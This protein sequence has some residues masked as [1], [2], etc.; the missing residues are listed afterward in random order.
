MFLGGILSAFRFLNIP[1][2]FSLLD[3]YLNNRTQIQ[4]LIEQ[5]SAKAKTE[6]ECLD[7]KTAEYNNTIEDLKAVLY[8]SGLNFE[9][10]SFPR[11]QESEKKPAKLKPDQ[12]ISN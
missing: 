9:S 7:K 8:R 5:I 4:I 6:I 10:I 3:S 2:T 1:I 12:Y 11:K